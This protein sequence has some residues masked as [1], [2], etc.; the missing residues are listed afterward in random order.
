MEKER[1]GAP[2]GL[3]TCQG[4]TEKGAESGFKEGSGGKAC[5]HCST[6]NQSHW[7]RNDAS[8]LVAPGVPVP[9]SP[10][11]PTYCPGGEHLTPRLTPIDQKSS[12][13]VEKGT[14][15][16]CWWECKLVQPLW[17]TVRRFLKKLKI[18][19]SYDPGFHS[20]AYTLR[21]P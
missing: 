13:Y 4:H 14:L 9:P 15:L 20:S 5:V 8:H 6:P 19:L 3:V 1:T 7:S 2:G 11:P 16:H 12:R 21:K 10:P 17:R 18:E